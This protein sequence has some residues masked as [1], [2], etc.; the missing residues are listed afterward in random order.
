[1]NGLRE[2]EAT[3]SVSARDGVLTRLLRAE[4]ADAETEVRLMNGEDAFHDMPDNAKQFAESRW[5]TAIAGEHLSRCPECFR[6]SAGG[7]L[8]IVTS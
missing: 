1:M 7:S 3:L 4:C 2:L 8:R 5:A 6:A